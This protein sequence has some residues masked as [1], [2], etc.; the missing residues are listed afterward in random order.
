[1]SA[2]KTTSESQPTPV[3]ELTYEQAFAELESLVASLESGEQSLEE[4]LAAF[5]RGQQ[6][7]RYCAGL[8]EGAELK[9]R[10]L[11]G[12]ELLDFDEGS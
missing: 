10:Q 1:M 11:S 8:L 5:E 4:A 9:I 7:A 2:K 3:E 6:L 12:E